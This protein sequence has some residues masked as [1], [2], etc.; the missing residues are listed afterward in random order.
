[1]QLYLY[2]LDIFLFAG[3]DSRGWAFNGL[4]AAVDGKIGILDVFAQILFRSRIDNQRNSAAPGNLPGLFDGNHVLLDGMMGFDIQNG[5]SAVTDSLFNMLLAAF[6][7]ISGFHH[8]AAAQKDHRFHRSAVLHIVALQQN[9]FILQHRLL[10]QA[11]AEPL[12]TAGHDGRH[13][14]RDA[15]GCRIHDN[16]PLRS[17]QPGNIIPRFIYEIRDLHILLSA[18]LHRLHDCIR[19]SRDP[20]D[21]HSPAGINHAFQSI[22]SM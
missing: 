13:R 21:T 8:P 1:M 9:D 15:A 17:E 12:I 3:D 6:I 2:P 7:G 18:L 10:M 16:R 22:S 14:Q 19:W 11:Q 5:C 4:G 20:K